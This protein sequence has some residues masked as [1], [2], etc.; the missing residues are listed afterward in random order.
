M[1]NLPSATIQIDESSSAPATGLGPVVIIACVSQSPDFVP[2]QMSS[3]SDLLAQYAYSQGADY[4]ALHIQKTRKPVIFVGVPVATAGAASQLDQSGVTGTSLVTVTAAASGIMEDTNASVSVLT[5]GT[6]GT[7]QIMLSLSLDGGVSSQK[8]RLG[9]ASSYTIPFVGIVLNFGAGT[10]NIGDVV[11]FVTKAPMWGS[12]AMSSARAALAAQQK[13]SQSWMVIGDLPNST[14][15]GYVE[16]E[17]NNYESENDRY[18]YAR[19]AVSDR[20]PLAKASKVLAHMEG[21]SSLSFDG[22]AHTIT[23]TGGS[24]T[25]DGFENGDVITVAGT[26]SNNG[27]IGA[28][29]TVS[30]TV[31]TF[32][33]G[34]TTE[35]S[36]TAAVTASEAITFASSGHTATRSRGSFLADGFATG[37]SVTFS[38][39]MSNNVTL[40]LTNVSSTVMTFGSGLS[41]EGPIAM[42]GVTIVENL[43]MAAWVSAQG[44]AFAVI[45]AAPRIDLG[46]GRA[47]AQSPITGWSLRRSCQWAASIREY[48]HDVQ[49]PTYRKSDGPLDGFSIA[50]ANGNIVEFDENTDGGG[51]A[52]RFTC[53]RSYS[54]GPQGAFVAL[55]LTRD[56]EGQILSRTHNMAVTDVATTTVQAET[57]NA[58]GQVLVLNADGTGTDASLSLIEQRVNT[59]LQIALLQNGS[60]GPR[61]SSAVWVASRSDVLNVVGATLHGTLTLNLN[62]TIEQIATRV[63]VQ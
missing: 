9:T 6:V 41:N 24:W 60:E 59:Q 23:R 28:V 63:L 61:A 35:T 29:T 36:T 50:D 19:A 10:L 17:A 42:S 53:L 13:G 16:T 30:S 8:V 31:L 5:G 54:N 47:T 37:Q 55:S 34:L 25:T 11:T 3:V 15:A 38:G 58:I 43:T 62:G 4:A 40:T 46:L 39:T 14:F 20:M 45:D 7:D 27:V 18:V 26:A 57:E 44:S 22:T 49:I 21:A 2:R 48:Q 32:A 56:T 1:P 33:S 51:L 12:T 52:G